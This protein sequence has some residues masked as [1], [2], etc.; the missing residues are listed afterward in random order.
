MMTSTPHKSEDI[1]A[2]IL[3][4]A[5]RI[6]TPRL[7]I[8]CWQPTDAHLLKAAVDANIEYLKPWTPWVKNEPEPLED[9]IAWIRKFRAKFDLNENFVYGVFDRDETEVIGGT[10]LHTRQGPE[11][12]EIGYWIQEKHAGKG[13]AT[14]VSAALTKV[15]FM[16]DKVK[17]VHIHCDVENRRS[18]RI[19]E[20]LGFVHEGNLRKRLP[21]TSD[22]LKDMMVWTMLI[23]EYPNSIPS[24]AEIEAF[25]V[26]GRRIL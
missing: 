24:K 12:R 23:D 21:T 20:K 26:I 7:C 17:R 16:I 15:A 3:G 8:R 11:A 4:S 6:S 18:S 14:E 1:Q 9:R 19:P 22:E 25:D 2:S 13:L 5:Y 10:G